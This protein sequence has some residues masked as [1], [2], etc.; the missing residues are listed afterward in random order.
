MT[1]YIFMV[2]AGACSFGVLS[3]IVKLAY[4]QGYHTAELSFLQA[5]TGMIV[6][7]GLFLIQKKT[8]AK[9][10]HQDNTL[11]HPKDYRQSILLL[12]TGATIGLASFVYYLSVIYIPASVAIVLLMQFTWIGILLDWI[13]LGKKPG[14]DQAITV[15]VIITGTIMASRL[16]DSQ[17][18]TLSLK[19]ILLGLG[20]A[21]L[22]GIYVVL[23]SLIKPGIP[24]LKKSAVMMAGS[25]MAV[26]LVNAP[27]L[28]FH[29]TFDLGI[30]KWIVLLAFFGTVIPPLLFSTGIPKVGAGY[31]TI[32]MTAELPVAV[33]CSQLILKEKV[34]FLQWSGIILILLAIIWLNRKQLK[35]TVL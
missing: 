17:V 16:L 30:L 25:A 33:I 12:V 1:P 10:P 11:T 32:L 15:I 26:F 13:F 5:V 3:S 4:Q 19:G 21:L 2:F 7:T 28:L 8:K 20:S 27:E 24:P 34:N 35:K 6:L 18:E 23:S 29:T 31:S 9:Q 14:P 22:F